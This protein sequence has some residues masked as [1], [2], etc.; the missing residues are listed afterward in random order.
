MLPPDSDSQAWPPPAPPQALQ[1]PRCGAAA[2]PADS[3][4]RCG[5]CRL[6]FVLR[7]GAFLDRAVQP[8]PLDPRAEVVIVKSSGALRRYGR[9][10]PDALVEGALDPLFARLPMTTTK[11]S[12]RAIYT[13]AVWRQIP[14]RS[15]L[16]VLLIPVPFTWALF[17]VWRADPLPG[18]LAMTLAMAALTLGSL[19]SIFL[20]QSHY[21]RAV[22]A[23]ETLLVRFDRPLFRR[24][25]F[26]DELLRRSGLSPSPLP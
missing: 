26:H 13:L 17:S 9:L 21:V 25:K 15:A 19:A 23:H 7:A 5:K 22:G 6:R 1:C 3:V 4:Q 11:L 10:D 20:V 2:K 8:P 12:Y 16:A 14:W 18:L 24:K